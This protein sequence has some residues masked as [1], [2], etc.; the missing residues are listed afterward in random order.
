MNKKCNNCPTVKVSVNNKKIEAVYKAQQMARME[1]KIFVVIEH[2]GGY[3][4][5]CLEC[6]N[7]L[8]ENE[9]YGKIVAYV[10]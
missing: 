6:Y 9:K 5:E 3:Q 8:P 4:P 7:K 1:K 10:R 2:N